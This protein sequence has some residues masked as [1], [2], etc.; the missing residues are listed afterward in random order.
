ML[1]RSVVQGVNRILYLFV[2]QFLVS[3]PAEI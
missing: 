1:S 3:C 2:L